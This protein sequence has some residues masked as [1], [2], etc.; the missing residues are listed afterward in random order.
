M[1]VEA[2]R[3]CG[4]LWWQV[5][6]VNGYFEQVL[7]E[8]LQAAKQDR[9][10]AYV[11]PAD[12]AGETTGGLLAAEGEDRVDAGARDTGGVLAAEVKERARCCGSRCRLAC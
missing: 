11:K 2:E 1:G 10:D 9:E 6:E 7:D 3:L 8:F 12:D 5:E 4:W